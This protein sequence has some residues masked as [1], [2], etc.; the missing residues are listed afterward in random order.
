MEK[1]FILITSP[2]ACGKTRLAKRLATQLPN[3]VYLDKDSLIPL[4]KQI[5]KV[6]RKPYNRSSE[7][8][9]KNIRDFEYEVIINQGMDAIKYADVVIIN[10]P[11]RKEVRSPEFIKDFKSRLEKVGAKL[12]VVWIS[13]TPEL[14]RKRMFKRN[15]DRDK[16]KI[17][18]WDE[19]VKTVNFDAPQISEE[20]LFIHKN[21]TDEEADEYFAKL[22]EKI[23]NG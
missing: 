2:P 21:S 22:L 14:C 3:A 18:H 6:A 1:R 17:E 23:E 9:K 16:W 19:Y 12:L 4:S 7:F 15:S 13:V 11:F 10:A 8:F 5:F 20:E